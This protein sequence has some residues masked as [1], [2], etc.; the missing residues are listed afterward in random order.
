MS[1]N[2]RGVDRLISQ[3]RP[4]YDPAGSG[5]ALAQAALPKDFSLH[6]QHP[7][8]SITKTFLN[9]ESQRDILTHACMP[10]GTL[11]LCNQE[12]HSLYNNGQGCSPLFFIW[13]NLCHL[14]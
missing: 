8:F 1:A 5:Q 14:T 9:T 12:A 4:V 3:A 13:V 11:C 10:E 2:A 7:C 6:L